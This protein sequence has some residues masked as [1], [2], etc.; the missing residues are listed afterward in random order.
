MIEWLDDAIGYAESWL[1]YQ[2][3]ATELP[4]CV[5][6]VSAGG[7]LVRERA[8]GVADL[9]TGEQLTPRHRFRVA[10]HSKTFT[11]AGILKLHEAGRL[12]LDDPVSRYVRDLDASTAHTTIGQLLSH[13]SGL[14]RDG[15]EA[16]F[17]QQRRPFLDEAELRA[18]LAK[19]PTIEANTRFKYSN[20]GFGLLGLV[21]EALTGES[22]VNWIM[23]EIVSPFAL[24]ETLADVPVPDGVPI[25]TGHGAVLPLGKRFIIEGRERT[26][27][28][29]SAT[30]FVSTAG[31]LAR[32]F[33]ALDPAAKESILSVKSR[34]EMTRSQWAVPHLRDGRSYGL[35]V[36]MGSVGARAWFGHSGAFPGFISRTSTVPEWGVTVSIVTNAIDGSAN[37]WVEGVLSIFDGFERRGAAEGPAAGWAGRWW[38]IWGAVDLVPAG[39]KVLVA[40]PARP[41]PF[42][43]ASE[44]EVSSVSQGRIA[45]ADGF[46]SHGEAVERTIGPDGAP[47]RL[48]LGGAEFVPEAALREEIASGRARGRLGEPPPNLRPPA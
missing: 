42:A 7:A 34:R 2:V 45:L 10:S 21:I 46:G 38:T 48:K 36:I 9:R 35:G 44:L 20:I 43:E 47:S 16:T 15:V 25:A 33:N 12:H 41:D 18:E 13:S 19:P 31:D 40:W 24:Q 30:G 29:A 39:R 14:V 27:A 23:R 22:Y 28:L 26:E 11:A 1:D 32:F 17:W 6:A 37:P 4:G 5:L 8:F 3:R